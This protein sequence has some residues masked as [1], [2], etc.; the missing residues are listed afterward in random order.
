MEK[1]ERLIS[2]DVMRGLIMI[3]LAAE[4]AQLYKSLLDWQ[5]PCILHSLVEQFFHHPWHGLRFWDLVQPAFMTIAGTAMYLSYI[6]KSKKGISWKQNFKH[7]ALRCLKLF[8]FGVLLHCVYAGR[9]VW[10]LWNVLT[11]LAVTSF[12]AYLIIRKS[13]GF[14]M[15]VS[16]LLIALTDLLYKFVTIPGFSL[17]YTEFYN[18]GAYMDIVLMKKLNP[19]GWVA[20]N[21]IPTAAHTIWGVLIG[22]TLIGG[23]TTRTKLLTLLIAGLSFLAIGYGLDALNIIPIIKRISTGSFVYVSGGWI[24]LIFAFL[25]WFIDLKQNY[26]WA[27]ITTV[28][29]MNA[30]FIYLFFETVGVQWVNPTIGIFVK[31]FCGWIQLSGPVQNVTHSLVVLISE[32]YLCYWL[33]KKKIYFKL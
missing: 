13:S 24:I 2:L 20:I 32:W 18:F 23:K 5:L 22:K 29:G 11:Q 26:K 30:I 15:I 27:W 7:I 16:L 31:G 25:Y 3:L 17:P 33:F 6:Q 4:S 19:D 10:E 21:F 1:S 8:F 12:I 28:V 14:Q 9:P